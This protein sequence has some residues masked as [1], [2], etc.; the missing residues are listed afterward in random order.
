MPLCSEPPALLTQ[1]SR[2]P[3]SLTVRRHQLTDELGVGDVAAD[4]DGP[5]SQAAHLL[6]RRVD[7]VLAPG[8]H[9]DVGSDLGEAKGDAATDAAARAGD[10]RDLPVEAEAVEQPAHGC[11]T[12]GSGIALVDSTGNPSIDLR[13]S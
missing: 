13:A 10:D 6:D 12:T 1:T 3:S 5:P 4:A 8:R 9:H 2:R 7:L 11:T